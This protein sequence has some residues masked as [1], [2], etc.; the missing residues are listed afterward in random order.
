MPAAH[1]LALRIAAN[2]P[3]A[4]RYAKEGLRRARHGDLQE[5]GTYVGNTLGYLFTTED[6]R[7]GALAFVEKREPVFRGR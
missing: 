3:L 6:H 2:A 1:E 7:E 4:L 5:L